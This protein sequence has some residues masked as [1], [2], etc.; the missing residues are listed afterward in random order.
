MSWKKIAALGVGGVLIGVGALVPGAQ[1]AIA[2]G[3][4]LVAWAVPFPGDKGRR[5]RPDR[6]EEPTQTDRPRR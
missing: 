1:G 6:T 2:A 3:V 4:G 5:A